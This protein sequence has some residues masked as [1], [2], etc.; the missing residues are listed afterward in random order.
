MNKCI[1]VG[2]KTKSCNNNDDGKKHQEDYFFELG[3]NKGL[4]RCLNYKKGCN[5]LL[6]IENK[7]CWHINEECN[8][9]SEEKARNKC[10]FELCRSKKSNENDYCGKHQMIYYE[11]LLITE[12]KKI[13]CNFKKGCRNTIVIYNPSKKCQECTMEDINKKKNKIRRKRP[14][15]ITDIDKIKE[16][17]EE[18]NIDNIKNEDIV[19]CNKCFNG[20]PKNYFMFKNEEQINCMICRSRYVKR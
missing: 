5:N 9:C 4:K 3:K 16:F 7:N 18:K 2:C 11:E 15:N 20:F 12:E 10:K 13:C 8:N 14:V 6:K 19:F 1:Y 17:C